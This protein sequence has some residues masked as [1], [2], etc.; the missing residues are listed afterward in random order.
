[1]DSMMVSS[2]CKKLT[3]LELVYTVIFN[4]IRTMH[5]VGE[6]LPETLQRY[7]EPH[8][9]KSMLYQTRTGEAPTKTDWLF[10]QADQLYRFIAEQKNLQLQQ[11]TAFLQLKRLLQEQCVITEEGI[12]IPIAAKEIAPD[13]LQNPSDPDATFRTKRKDKHIGYVT[14]IVE[15]RDQGKKVSLVMHHEVQP[16]TH[17]DAQ[18]GEDFITKQD[19]AEK[20]DNLS[21]DGA[22]Y[23][24]DT[25][26]KAQEKQ[27]IFSV[28]AMTGGNIPEERI[29]VSE[30][31]INEITQKIECCPGGKTPLYAEYQENKKVY[32]AKFAKPDCENCPFLS[33]C[34]IEIKQ[35]MN[36][37]RF[38]EKKLQAD[39]MRSVMASEEYRKLANFRAGVEGIP[40]V[41]RR[42]YRIDQIPSRGFMRL[43]IWVHCKVMAYNVKQIV[44]YICFAFLNF[45]LTYLIEN[46]LMGFGKL[47][48]VFRMKRPLFGG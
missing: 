17:S 43:K 37:L 24:A 35:E 13:S 21:A 9:K 4:M 19:L 33:R 42:V 28:S 16:N 44:R 48:L 27:M 18:F 10:G 22:Y 8:H 32:R 34:P 7:L 41:L 36:T 40:S 31:V 30:F 47:R 14:N 11:T 15:V 45:S 23:R 1:M 46:I 29:K 25:I 5:N 20:I 3:R 38:T 2:S 12:H 39:R 26:Q 6:I